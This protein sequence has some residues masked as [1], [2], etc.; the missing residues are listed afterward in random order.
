[1]Q[2]TSYIAHLIFDSRYGIKV[3]IFKEPNFTSENEKFIICINLV[4]FVLEEKNI[5]LSELRQDVQREKVLWV[6]KIPTLKNLRKN[7]GLADCW[8]K[9]SKMK[10]LQG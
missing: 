5:S 2:N 9:T 1:M 3:D 8:L 4:Y 7:L 6:V 10:S